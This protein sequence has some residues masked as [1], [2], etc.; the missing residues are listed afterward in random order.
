MADENEGEKPAEEP[1]AAAA[2]EAP[3]GSDL[4]LIAKGITPE[5]LAALQKEK[6]HPS[7]GIGP[8]EF[9]IVLKPDELARLL[10][11]QTELPDAVKAALAAGTAAAKPDAVQPAAVDDLQPPAED[12]S[13]PAA[14]DDLQPA[15]KD[16]DTEEDLLP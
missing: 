13:P 15:A 10:A 2:P 11:S 7:G 12:A 1:A 3:K 5:I 6:K 14:V 16:V 9:A 8:D 4:L